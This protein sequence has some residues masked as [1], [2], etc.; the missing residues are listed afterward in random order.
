MPFTSS[1]IMVS[2]FSPENIGS[3]R[4]LLQ[5]SLLWYQPMSVSAQSSPPL[6]YVCADLGIELPGPVEE[7]SCVCWLACS[8]HSWR[9]GGGGGGQCGFLKFI[10]FILFLAALGHCC[11]A[12]AFSS[13]SERGLLFVAVRWLLIAVASLVAEHWLSVRGL[14]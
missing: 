8:T 13:C 4:F 10:Y 7:D 6:V 1:Q 3:C 11:Y 5:L 9:R 12:R 14:Q 2:S